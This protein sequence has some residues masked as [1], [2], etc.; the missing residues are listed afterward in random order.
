[1]RACRQALAVGTGIRSAWFCSCE[2]HWAEVRRVSKLAANTC[3]DASSQE[4][5]SAGWLQDVTLTIRHDRL[6]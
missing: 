5:R 6:L 2:F 1:M 3:V 4:N